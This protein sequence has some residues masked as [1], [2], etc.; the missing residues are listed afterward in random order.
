MGKEIP[1]KKRLLFIAYLFPP[2]GGG[3]VQRSVKFAKYLPIFHWIPH[4]LTVKEPFDYYLDSSLE[5]DV[6]GEAV[7]HRTFAIEP[8]KWVR[9]FL[10]RKTDKAFHSNRVEQAVKK[11]SVKPSFLVWLKT[12]LLV[13]DNEILWLPFAVWQG[14]RVIRKEKIDLIFSTA[15]PFTDHLIGF[16][17]SRLTGLPWTADFRDFWVDRANFPA[18]RWRRFIDRKLERLVLK[19]A[20]HVITATSLIARRFKEIHSQQHYTVITNGYDDEDFEPCN[21]IRPVNNYFRITY[22]GIFNREQNPSNFFLAYRQFLEQREEEGKRIK[23][24][25]VGQ[26]DNPGDFENYHFLKQLGIDPY[27]E[28][29]SY[30]PHDQVVREMCEAT[31]LML[32]IGEYPHNEAVMTGKIFEYLRSGRPILAVVPPDGVAAEVILQTN[33]GIVVPNNCVSE[34]VRGI[35]VLYDLFLQGALDTKFKRNRITGYER[36][37]LTKQLAEIFNQTLAKHSNG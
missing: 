33:S 37:H 10:K 25:L 1:E 28:I 26:L 8:M 17:L 30:L 29:V 22:T 24:R 36:K 35:S 9:K 5:K 6:T 32:L 27:V 2:S 7:I 12:M 31:V 11:K 18:S 23:L 34:I 19:H 14:W 16:I 13:P 4:V 21:R 3:G 20:S 15:S